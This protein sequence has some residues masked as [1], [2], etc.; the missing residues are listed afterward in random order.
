MPFD[1]V[2]IDEDHFKL[3]HVITIVGV[4]SSHCI[5]GSHEEVIMKDIFE[6]AYG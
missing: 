4:H 2:Y 1:P 3:G 6:Q 5:T